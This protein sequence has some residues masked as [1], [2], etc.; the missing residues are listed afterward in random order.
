M[1]YH[2]KI[3]CYQIYVT[4]MHHLSCLNI[5][6]DCNNENI[7]FSLDECDENNTMSY[8]ESFLTF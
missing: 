3:A 7:C 8:H 2:V 6:K 1:F 5:D 4:F